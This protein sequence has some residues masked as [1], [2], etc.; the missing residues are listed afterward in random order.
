MIYREQYY[1]PHLLRLALAIVMD[2]GT[3]N[4]RANSFLEAIRK[5]TQNIN[6]NNNY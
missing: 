5:T 6:L 1:A 2:D 4:K 3:A